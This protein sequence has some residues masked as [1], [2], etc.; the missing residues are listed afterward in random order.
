MLTDLACFLE[1]VREIGYCLRMQVSLPEG[2]NLP[3]LKAT[4]ASN[5]PFTR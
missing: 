1:S 5:R 4:P 2:A 3:T